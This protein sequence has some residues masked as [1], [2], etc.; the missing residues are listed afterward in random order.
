MTTPAKD[1]LELEDLRGDY[2]NGNTEPVILG[3]D[4]GRGAE[5]MIAN[6]D[7]WPGGKP[8]NTALQDR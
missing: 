2:I 1:A 7:D 8:R 6:K 4:E 3:A 5:S